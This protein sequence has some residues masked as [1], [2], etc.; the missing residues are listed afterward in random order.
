[1]NHILMDS[2]KRYLRLWRGSPRDNLMGLAD[3]TDL[4]L[5]GGWP[6]YQPDACDGSW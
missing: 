1:M 6:V 2:I 3:P 5:G 4:T